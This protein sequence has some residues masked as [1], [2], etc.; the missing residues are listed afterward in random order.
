[1]IVR[2]RTKRNLVKSSTNALLLVTLGLIPSC[3]GK[4]ATLQ[5]LSEDAREMEQAFD[6]AKGKVRLLLLISP[7]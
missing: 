3:S 4:A 6:S 2:R 5:E 1:M 7:G